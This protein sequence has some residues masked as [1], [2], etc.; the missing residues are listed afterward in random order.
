M[1][2]EKRPE[3]DW[4]EYTERLVQRGK[5]LLTVESLAG[6]Q[7]ELFAMN[8]RKNGRPSRYPHSLM[9]FLGTLRVVFSLPYRQLEGFARRWGKLISIPIPDYS[10][11]SLRIP[12]LDIDPDLGYRPRKGEGVIAVDGTGIK[13]TNCGEWMRKEVPKAH[14]IHQDP[15]GGRHQ[16]QAGGEPGSER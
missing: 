5:I 6:W 8:L 3:R 11:L 14:F 4:K 2:E 1:T 12:K 7:E 16:D 13:V 9:L 10:T 15:C